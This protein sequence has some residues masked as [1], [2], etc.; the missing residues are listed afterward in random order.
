MSVDYVAF[1]EMAVH[2]DGIRH[3]LTRARERAVLSVLL[4]SHGSPVAAERLLT[5]VWGD[6]SSGQTLGALQV[7][8]SRLRGRLEP[9]RG[10]RKGSR[11]VSTAAGYAL[12]AGQDDVDTW[13][14][15]VLARSALEEVDASDLLDRAQAACALWTGSP[16][17]G[18]ES[19]LVREERHRLEELRLTVE[20][21]QARALLDL[22]RPEDA[23][24]ALA[25]LA[26]G[27]PFRERLWALLA[28][29][30]YRCAR[31][32]DALEVLRTLRSHL[33]DEL[34]V[35]PSDEVR[36]LEQQVLRQDAALLAAVAPAVRSPR[37]SPQRRAVEPV[38]ARGPGSTVGRESVLGSAVSLLEEASTACS[39]R[40]LLVAGEPGIGKSRLVEDLAAAARERG[41]RSL[42][43]RCHEGEY[44]PALWPWLSIVR[45]L[46]T[47]HSPTDP[48]LRPLLR[49]DPERPDAGGGT[50]LRMFDAV[51]ELVR[52]SALD[53][54]LLLVLEDV[55]WADDTSLHLLRHLTGSDVPAPVMV[56]CTRRTTEA[57]TSPALLDALAALARAGAERMRLDGLDAES[58]G[59]LLQRDI[60][61]VPPGLTASVAATTGGNPFFVLQYARLLASSPASRSADP[62][63]LPVP[64]GI[65]DVLRQRIHRL[66]DEA[67]RVLTAAAVMGDRVES[68]LLAELTG[69]PLEECLDLLDLALTCGLLEERGAGFAFVHALE[70]ETLYAE[71]SAPRRMRLHDLAGRIIE[72]RRPDDPDAGATI[73]HHTHRAA[74]LGPEHAERA[75]VWLARAAHV[76][77]A[78]HA[79]PEALQLWQMVV[80]NAP[81]SSLATAE[82]LYGVAGALLRLARTAEA[83]EAV[84]RAARL[85]GTLGRWD[86]VARA[87]AILNGAGVWSWREHGTKDDDFIELLSDAV[88]HVGDADRA[89]LLATLQM[90]HYYGWDGDVAERVGNESLELARSCG[91]RALLL[92]VLLVRIISTWRPGR[93]D[94]RLALVREVLAHRP[95][96]ELRV[97]ILFQLGSALYEVLDAEGADEAMRRCADEAAVLRHTGVEIPLAWWRYARAR[98][99][100]DAAAAEIGRTALELHRSSGYI[101]LDD[102]SC[103]H[104]IRSAPTGAPVSDDVV[105]AARSCNAG[106][107]ALVA[108]AALEAGDHGTA[109]ELLGEAAPPGAGDYSVLAGRCLRVLVLAETGSR[110]EVEDALSRITPY[111][112]QS[113]TYGT[114]EHLGAVDHFI[115]CGYAALEDPRALA[116]ARQAVVLNARMQCAPWRRRSEA[117]V[118]R[119]AG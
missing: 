56:V 17:D 77:T 30:H 73:A 118:A 95:E 66:P 105:R 115:A 67:V 42:V 79:H 52:R 69:T 103:L 1:G 72:A 59:A 62:A 21:R 107:R 75:C 15:D 64:D 98:D 38:P 3:P 54:P 96:G 87:A 94:L 9:A 112:G 10:A 31:Q 29:A 89:R 12:V 41:W 50:G 109:S 100:D 91:D 80:L 40:F 44:A 8:I 13:R 110:A 68:E 97:L 83:R 43:G 76:A 6:D 5:E 48:L 27:H 106:L 33:A 92:E 24:R 32:A 22:G 20:E 35:D 26:A 65:R 116:H 34:G 101:N 78:R 108:H 18:S 81:A 86:V 99:L 58:V 88:A 46:A 104:A 19:P 82:A 53:Q 55:H 117:L 93:G 14:F 7:A 16:Y 36:L 63:E 113:V 111:A 4:A 57:G 49:T 51:V 47:T 45:E 28:L 60:A 11:L 85:A 23:Q 119:L 71:L 61:T 25:A 90:E 114:V 39:S 74:P 37:P 84:D 102:L 2:V 70:R